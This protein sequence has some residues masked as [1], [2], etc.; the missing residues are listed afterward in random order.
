MVNAKNS[1]ADCSADGPDKVLQVS[2]L[3]HYAY[4][5]ADAEE[6]RHFYEDVLGLPLKRVVSHDHVPS[7]GE[8]APYCH[9]FF[10]L[11]D[12]SHIAFFDVFD[13]RGS[14]LAEDVPDWL[15]HI[16]LRVPDEGTLLGFKARLENAGYEVLGPVTH[17][18]MSSI[19]F[20]DPNGH[21]VEF[22][23]DHDCD[24]ILANDARIAHDKLKDV[25]SKYAPL[26]PSAAKA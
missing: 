11:E 1:A 12:G 25:I 18:V 3:H 4:R 20:F 8:Y 19:Y 21:R 6:T 17:S 26:R 16:A 24:D 13:G 15:H 14:V 22:V 9:I 7:T 23:W 10:E 5:C 2:R